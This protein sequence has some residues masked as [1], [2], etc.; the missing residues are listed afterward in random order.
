MRTATFLSALFALFLAPITLAQTPGNCILGTAEND[1]D[2]NNVLARTFNTG[3][4]FFGNTTVSG[5]GYLVPQNAGTSPIFASGLWVAGQ[6]NGELRAAGSTYNDFEFWPGPLNDDGTLPAPDDCAQF[7]RIYRVSREDIEDYEAGGA[8]AIDLAEWPVGLGAPTIDA[9]GNPVEPASM[10]QLIDLEAGERPDINDADQALWWV[11]N[12]V[13]NVHQN[14]LTP[15]IG[16]EVRVLAYAYD[17]PDA[18]G[19]ATFYDIGLTY[20][21]NE[22][23]EEAYLGV[24]SDPDLGFASDDYVGSDPARSLGFAYN[25]TN[26]DDVYGTPPPAVGYDLLSCPEGEDGESLGRV[27]YF[28]NV[29]SSPT[30]DPAT[31]EGV[32]NYLQGL[33]RDGTPLTVGGNG[34]DPG[35]DEVTDFAFSGNPP[36]FWSELD[37][38]GNGTSTT[39]GDRRFLIS[40]GPLTLAPGEEQTITVGILWAIGEDHLDSVTE[41]KAAS[42]FIQQ[43]FDGCALVSV[44]DGVAPS[45]LSLD[46]A[47]P[48]PFAAETALRLSLDAPG[49]AT[50]EVLDVL[51]RRVDVLLD[52][53]IPAGPRTL[54]WRPRAALPNGVY[55]VRMHAGGAAVTRAVVLQR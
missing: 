44:E 28:E 38:D 12:D 50:V 42:D 23:L 5:D 37:V 9:N 34:Y 48:N 21:G 54:V 25:A 18:Y 45:G 36:E 19:D 47:Y 7:D 46:P 8:P 35:S 6:L 55:F 53:A 17:R 14:N 29:P 41:L 10:D 15:P 1:L 27:M 43:D 51:G 4:L 32:Y 11:M 49:R 22:V 3:S 2:V 31:A 30:S 39:P 26:F 20:K 24:F 13:G 52:E 40:N 16:L 33:W